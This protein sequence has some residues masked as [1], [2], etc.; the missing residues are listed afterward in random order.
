MKI[1]MPYLNG[2][3]DEYFGRNGEFIIV[4]A[5]DG[6]ITGK[7][8]LTSETALG[9]LVGMF[10]N[11]GVEVVIAN[12]ISR[13]VVEM[14]FYNGIRVITRASGEVEQVAKDFLSGELLTGAACRGS[15]NHAR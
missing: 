1:A 15:G 10:Q 8:I 7:K 11:E 3:V 9:D 5:D 6:M 4:E 2:T 14:F 13:P 12:V